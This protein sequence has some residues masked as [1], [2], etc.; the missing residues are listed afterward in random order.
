MESLYHRF[1]NHYWGSYTKLIIDES[2]ALFLNLWVYLV[3]GILITSLI[4]MY[5]NKEQV[6]GF[7]QRKNNI[8]IVFAALIGVV[9]PL[10]SYIVIPLSAALFTMGVPLPVLMALLVSSPLIDPNLFLLTAGAFGFEVA[11][12]R[13]ISAFLLGTLAGYT[14]RWLIEKQKIQLNAIL[15]PNNAVSS[16]SISDNYTRPTLNKFLNEL[17][18]MTRFI[19]KYFFLAILLAALIK[20]LT[21]P[22]LMIRMFGQNNFLSVLLSTGA[23]ISFYVCG[24]AA[25]P[26][27]EQLADLGMS[28]GAVLAF[29]ISGPVTKISNLI[30]MNAIFRVRIFAVYLT[31]GIC[32]AA[33]LGLIYNLFI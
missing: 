20:I 17:Y 12:A 11:F 15:N 5:L 6:A 23:G 25:I 9:S 26:I 22:N 21:P 32:G 1:L 7:L 30:L 18:R 19:S 33:I 16:M 13:L 31:V 4:K 3:L 27:V 29:F 28:K 14:T 8:T 2:I 10:G 24:G